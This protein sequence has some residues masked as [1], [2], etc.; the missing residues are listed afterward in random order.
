MRSAHP[1]KAKLLQLDFPIRLPL[2]E[3]GSLRASVF[4]V[5]VIVVGFPDIRVIPPLAVPASACTPPPRNARRRFP[6]LCGGRSAFRLCALRWPRWSPS[7]G[8]AVQYFGASTFR[9]VL[10]SHAGVPLARLVL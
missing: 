5:T 3:Y 10:Y 4:S 1:F 2:G 9:R 7:G 8:A 6:Q